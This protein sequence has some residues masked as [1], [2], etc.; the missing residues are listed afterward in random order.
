[1][2]YSVFLSHASEDIKIAQLIVSHAGTIDVQVYLFER[3]PQLGSS[4]SEKVKKEIQKSDSVIVLLTNTSQSSAYVHQEIGFAEGLG[5]LIIPFVFP[6]FNE[7]N[8]ALLQG[9]EY[10]LF[11]PNNSQA[12]I[13][14]LL[15]FLNKKKN[16]K[17]NT[18][19][20]LIT[21]GGLLLVGLLAGNK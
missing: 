2:S 19:A 15:E 1:M 7:K 6:G 3:H 9:R 20:I 11:D 4:V 18:D 14:N 12:A 17:E 13:K 16:S 8:F 10:V 21:L 5:K